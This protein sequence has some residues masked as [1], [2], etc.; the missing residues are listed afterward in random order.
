MD[1]AAHSGEDGGRGRTL[2]Y[3]S[4]ALPSCIFGAHGPQAHG[5]RIFA[6][7][8]LVP[9][10]APCNFRLSTCT[11][12]SSRLYTV[13]QL[14]G[15]CHFLRLFSFFSPRYVPR[16]T[17]KKE[18]KKRILFVLVECSGQSIDGGTDRQLPY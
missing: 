8:A 1:G 7:G 6:R 2:F 13:P 18:R 14:G 12:L 16:K 17:R 4:V 10:Q 5:S 3:S 15:P 9:A 11:P